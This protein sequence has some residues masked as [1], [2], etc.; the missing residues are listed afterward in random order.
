MLREGKRQIFIQYLN[1]YKP[2]MHF[3]KLYVIILFGLPLAIRLLSEFYY[4][5]PDIFK[6]LNMKKQTMCTVS[7]VYSDSTLSPG[8]TKPPHSTKASYN[9]LLSPL[10]LEKRSRLKKNCAFFC[11]NI[12]VFVKA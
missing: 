12:L 8:N 11:P 1:N 7:T 5:F 6:V 2:S 3:K 10:I 9:D 4:I